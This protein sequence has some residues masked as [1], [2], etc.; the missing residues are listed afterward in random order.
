MRT[1]VICMLL[2]ALALPAL[3]VSQNW[4]TN[5]DFE[6]G[7]SGWTQ[8][9]WG[10]KSLPAQAFGTL[11][12]YE[13]NNPTPVGATT[14]TPYAGTSVGWARTNARPSAQI[15][16]FV[17]QT[18]VVPAGTY[19]VANATWKAISYHPEPSTKRVAAMF[20]VRK[21]GQIGSAYNPDDANTYVFR[22]TA[23]CDASQGNWIDKSLTSGLSFTTTTG[24]VQFILAYQD[25]TGDRDANW[26]E[27]AYAGFDNVVFT[28]NQPIPEPS[29][30]LALGS[31]LVGLAGFAIRRRR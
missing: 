2:T 8:G 16:I 26:P 18:V 11:N 30:L 24:Q 6:N 21:D 29:S 27:Y 12:A 25:L 28:T 15:W 13:F 19:T 3:A 9:Q 7:L 10:T 5:G 17:S 14:V 31:S 1:V 20:L 4:I 22:S 23:W